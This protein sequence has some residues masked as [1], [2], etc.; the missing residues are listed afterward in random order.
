[1]SLEGDNNGKVIQGFAPGRAQS[2]TLAVPWVPTSGDVAFCTSVNCT[3]TL[4]A[5]SSMSLLAGAVRVIRRG[6]TYTFD[7]T[8]IIEVM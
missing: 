2:V 5:G 1:M 3:Y 6:Y 7:T 8:M 4:N